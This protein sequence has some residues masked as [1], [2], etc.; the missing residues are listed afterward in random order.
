M[1][2]TPGAEESECRYVSTLESEANQS[3]ANPGGLY[4]GNHVLFVA[5]CQEPPKASSLIRGVGSLL[6]A[7][8]GCRQLTLGGTCP[9]ALR[10]RNQ[11]TIQALDNGATPR[12][13]E[14][15]HNG[16]CSQGPVPSSATEAA[17]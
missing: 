2:A 5:L 7:G 3:C 12:N 16:H 10:Q 1:L 9:V 15:T 13:R 17:P 14:K 4:A 11:I 8:V 6:E